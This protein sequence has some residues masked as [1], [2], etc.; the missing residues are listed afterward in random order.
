MEVA[1]MPNYISAKEAAARAEY[2]DAST[3]RRAIL[4]GWLKGKKLGGR[5]WLIDEKDFQKWIDLGSP[6]YPKKK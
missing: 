6:V 4:N 5:D 2:K 3:I 1:V